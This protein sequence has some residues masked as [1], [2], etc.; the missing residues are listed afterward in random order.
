MTVLQLKEVT[1]KIERKTPCMAVHADTG[2]EEAHVDSG[3]RHKESVV[4]IPTYNEAGNLKLLIPSI[5]RQG[6]FDILII[7][8]NSP[9]GTG[10]VAEELARRFPGRVT[11][12]HRPGKL[13]LGTAYLAG[14]DYALAQDYQQVFT[15]DADF[16]HDPSYLP[17]LREALAEADVVLGSRYMPGGGTLRWP[18]WRRLLSRGGSA[19][20]RLILG[21][22]IRDL[23]GGFKGFRRQ[24]LEALL[25]EL[26]TIRSTGYSFQI[27]MTYRCARHGFRI[28]EIPILFEDRLVGKSKMSRRIVAEA[29]WVVWALRLSQGS[30]QP[31]RGIRP[32]ARLARRRVMTAVMALV[33]LVL[34]LGAGTL[35]P[36]Q[37]SYLLRGGGAV[38]PVSPSHVHPAAPTSRRAMPSLSATPN[39][40]NASSTFIQLQ[41]EDLTSNATLSFVGSGFLPSEELAVAINYSDGQLAAQLAPVTA[42]QTG[43]VSAASNT[44]LANL[45]PGFLYLQVMGKRSHRWAQASF[46]L[47]RIPPTAQLDTYTVKPEHEV[48][49]SGSGFMSNEAV[50]VYLGSVGNERLATVSANAGGNVA[51]RV[52]VPVIAEGNYTLLFMGRQSRTSTSVGL[53]VQGFHPWVLLDNYVPSSHTRLG[54]TGDDFAPNEEVLVYL[55]QREGKPVVRIQADASGRFAVS[56][57][58]EVGDLTGENTLIFV[59]QQSG[60]VVTTTFTMLPSVVSSPSPTSR[61]LNTETAGLLNNLH[62]LQ[63]TFLGVE[64]AGF[65]LPSLVLSLELFIIGL[66]VI[67]AVV[68]L[69]RLKFRGVRTKRPRRQSQEIARFADDKEGVPQRADVRERRQI[70]QHQGPSLPQAAP[71][72]KKSAAPTGQRLADLLCPHCSQLVP[73]GATFCSHCGVLLVA[74]ESG[75]HVRLEPPPSSPPETPVSSQGDPPSAQPGPSSEDGSQ[76]SFPSALPAPASSVSEEPRVEIVPSTSGNEH[77]DVPRTMV[78]Y[79]MQL[80]TGLV[81]GALSHPGIKRQHSP[82]EDSLF[83]AQG[84]RAHAAQPQRF[85]VF[86]VADGMGGH[87]HGQEASCQAIQTMIDQMLPKLSENRELRETDLRQLLIDGVQAANQAIY[88]R[89]Q[90]QPSTMGT[91]ITAALVVGSTAFV[92]NV[93]DSRTYLYREAEGLRKVTK[94]HSVVAYLAETGIIKPDDIYTHPQRNQIYR[95]LGAQPLV[96]VDVFIEHLQLGDTLLLCSDGLWEMVRDPSIQ[97]TLGN[98]TDPSQISSALIEAALVGGGADNVSVIVVQVTEATRQTGIAGMQLLTKPD[99]V[100]MSNLLYSEPK[101]SPQE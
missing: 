75:Q 22:P 34:F 23:T 82:N 80:S 87:T 24:V 97:Q 93:G 73:A 40:P 8:D 63:F 33:F 43:H 58:W 67:L 47:H 78:S 17:T 3:N 62:E 4:I 39:V 1:M 74:S 31:H 29:L 91:T 45:A 60:A 10:E 38:Q 20:A 55:N 13:G 25:P 90:L 66:L 85:G 57:A 18:L 28:M 65:T 32:R 2:Q 64:V 46:R 89:N 99:A 54:F 61:A 11:V 81:V 72:V 56:A 14:F 84:M 52:M 100:E 41:G 49:F 71:A 69:V 42:D 98:G 19:Y 101:Q 5:L 16:S 21:L 37:L 51:G 96:Q 27:E 53:N 83:A 26:E 50:D 44:I 76:Q 92:A 15:M 70:Q 88:Q 48:G 36:K 79:E 94:D 6:P 7:D 59:G 12:L 86:L 9:D 68:V 35:A 95:N 77:T 30:A